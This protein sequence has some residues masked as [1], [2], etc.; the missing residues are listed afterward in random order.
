[1][2]LLRHEQSCLLFIFA[3]VINKIIMRNN[4]F[5]LIALVLIIIKS[6]INYAQY[7]GLSAPISPGNIWVSKQDSRFEKLVIT[8][9]LI[10]IDSLVYNFITYSPPRGIS[11]GDGKPVRLKWNNDIVVRLDST[12]PEVHNEFIY[13]KKNCVIGDKWTQTNARFNTSQITYEVI[14]TFQTN[15]FDNFITV[16]AIYVTDGFLEDMEYWSEKFGFL[17]A[18]DYYYLK[19]CIIDGILYGDTSTVTD[20]KD[21]EG[22]IAFQDYFLSQNYPNPFNPS[23]IINYNVKYSGLV[24]LKVYDILGSEVATLVNETKVAGNFAV[25]FNTANLP[26]GVYIYT[27]QVNGFSESRKML[28]MK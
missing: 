20:V 17:Q 13:Y 28:L 3:V 22:G 5:I 6:E 18:G 8:D 21:E 11:W 7:M 10:L 15:I 26:S 23:T 14:D 12:Y 19:G 9:S 24:S 1:M 4:N 2:G 25:E 27:L 16:K